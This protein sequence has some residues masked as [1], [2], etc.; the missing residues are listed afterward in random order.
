MN[1]S[2]IDFKFTRHFCSFM[3][4]QSSPLKWTSRDCLSLSTVHELVLNF[5]VLFKFGASPRTVNYCQSNRIG[6]VVYNLVCVEM[7]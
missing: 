7:R 5:Q 6:V 1:A 2:V 4:T 3:C